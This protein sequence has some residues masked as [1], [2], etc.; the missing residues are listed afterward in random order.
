ME[1]NNDSVVYE[2]KFALYDMIRVTRGLIEN[3]GTILSARKRIEEAE[4]I[5]NKNFNIHDVLRS[6]S[7]A[8]LIDYATLRAR[9]DKMEQALI[10]AKET[11]NWMWQN[12]KEPDG[13]TLLQVD[14]FNLP[15]NALHII[16]LALE[17]PTIPQQGGI[18][19]LEEPIL[20]DEDIKDI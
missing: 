10:E 2:L 11:V 9:A 20:N 8:T 4:K 19:K 5:L 15:A 14:A 13:Q 3:R 12:M 7:F 18:P 17:Q 16:D 1:Q 6:D